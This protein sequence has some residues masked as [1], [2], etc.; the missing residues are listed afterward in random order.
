MYLE[1]I[2]EFKE[3]IKTLKIEEKEQLMILAGGDSAK[4]IEELI[5]FLN[6]E[7]INFFRAYMQSFL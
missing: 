1:T 6:D 4:Y 2:R 3:F 5:N 7:K